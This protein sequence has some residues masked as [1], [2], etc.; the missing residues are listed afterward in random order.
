M[1]IYQTQYLPSA[2]STFD[3]SFVGSV[4]WVCGRIS[5]ERP[6]EVMHNEKSGHPL[7]TEKT[8]VWIS[9]SVTTATEP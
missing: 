1:W 8:D 9:H 7:M 2:Y 5:L 6:K 4:S 3:N